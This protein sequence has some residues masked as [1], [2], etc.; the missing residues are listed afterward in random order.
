MNN[1]LQIRLSELIA[2]KAQ[3]RPRGL[4]VYACANLRSNTWQFE[5]SDVERNVIAWQLSAL[6][7][8]YRWTEATAQLY[9]LAQA[10]RYIAEYQPDSRIVAVCTTPR[11]LRGRGTQRWAA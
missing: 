11:R 3:A 5:I 4:R 6:P 2:Y 9:A 7:T 1:Q 8:G 10:A